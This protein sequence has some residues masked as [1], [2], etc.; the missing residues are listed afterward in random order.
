MRRALAAVFAGRGRQGRGQPG[1]A[2]G[3]GRLGRLERPLARRTSRSSGSSSTARS[4]ACGS[5]RRRPR[6]RCSSRSACAADGQKVLLAVKN[7]GGES[8]AAW[9][10]LLD[11]L[12]KRGLKTPELVIVDGAPGLEKALA[13][14]WPD[15][16]VQRCT[17]HK[18]RNL[19]AHA[20]ERL[21]EEISERLQRHDLRRDE[22]GDRG[23]A[24]GVHP[25][26]AA[27]MPA[28]SPTA[29]RKPATSCSPSRA[30]RKANGNRSEPRTRSNACTR[31]SSGGSRRKPCCPAPKPPPCCSGRCWPQARSPCAR[32]T[33]GKASPRSHPIRSLTSP[34]DRI[35]S[36]KPGDAPPNSNT[37]RDGTSGGRMIKRIFVL[38]AGSMILASCGGD[39]GSSG[40][41]GGAGGGGSPAAQTCPCN[42]TNYPAGTCIKCNGIY[43]DRGSSGQWTPAQM[44]GGGAVPPGCR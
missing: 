41:S 12:V 19:L 27:E 8:E 6:S 33:A 5:T 22:A 25:Q 9:R 20:P 43:Q 34:H 1:L 7:M 2:Q 3:E 29:W 40:N 15:V 36:M 11:D 38:V 26:M 42:S 32:S 31:S 37:I 18:H 4:C 35:A 14:L 17:V 44:G 30:S 39:S 28:P 13:A 10:A 23:E 21:H 16:P 24:Q